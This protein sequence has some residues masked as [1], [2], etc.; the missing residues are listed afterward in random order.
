M[1][2]LH[3]IPAV[4]PKYGGPSNALLQICRAQQAHGVD[5]DS[6][7]QEWVAVA[8]G[9]PDDRRQMDHDVGAAES[10]L[11]QMLIAHVALDEI[12]QRVGTEMVEPLLARTVHE[13]VQR[14]HFKAGAEEMLT[15]DAAKVAQAAGHENA[16]CHRSLLR[17]FEGMLYDHARFRCAAPRGLSP[18]TDDR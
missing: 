9:G 2:V 18:W 12:K 1:K 7:R 13:V 15:N 16:L 11:H 3:V 10:G 8:G 14:R 6:R 4:S 5:V 17:L